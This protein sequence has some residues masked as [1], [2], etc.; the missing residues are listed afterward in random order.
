MKFTWD[1]MQVINWLNREQESTT[2]CACCL[3]LCCLR[4][5]E[6]E[7]RMKQV[8]INYSLIEDQ[9][10]LGWICFELWLFACFIWLHFSLSNCFSHYHCLC[11]LHLVCLLWW[12]CSDSVS[13]SWYKSLVACCG[14]FQRQNNVQI[15]DINHH[16]LPS[17][18]KSLNT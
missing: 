12:L 8:G 17:R 7:S 3:L 15:S 18:T 10:L 5:I 14:I 13:Y 6:S 2:G 16:I 1:W 11:F 4:R 9:M